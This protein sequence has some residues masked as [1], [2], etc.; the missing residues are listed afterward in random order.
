MNGQVEKLNIIEKLQKVLILRNLKNND[1]TAYQN[2]SSLRLKMDKEILELA[3]KIA[4]PENYH[5]FPEHYQKSKLEQTTNKG[6]LLKYLSPNIQEQICLETPNLLISSSPDIQIKLGPSHPELITSFDKDTQLKI[7]FQNGDLLSKCYESVQEEAIKQKPELIYYCSLNIKRDRLIENLD[8]TLWESY[9]KTPNLSMKNDELRIL[10]SQLPS[11]TKYKYE[12][13]FYESRAEEELKEN[14]LFERS[15]TINYEFAKYCN[16]ETQN[17]IYDIVQSISSEQAA[18]LDEKRNSPTG[19]YTRYQDFSESFILTKLSETYG[20]DKINEYKNFINKLYQKYPWE[21]QHILGIFLNEKS[22]IVEKV[23]PK[24]VINFLEDYLNEDK[25]KERKNNHEAK[26]YYYN[27]FFDLI[28]EAYGKE[29]L[30]ILKE[31]PGLNFEDI[32]NLEVF[33]PEI[34]NNFS[35]GFIHDLLNYDFGQ[36]EFDITKIA[37]NP[38]DLQAFKLYYSRISKILGENATTMKICISR[39]REY[40]NILKEASKQNL[41]EEQLQKLDALCTWPKNIANI[42]KIEELDNLE[43]KLKKTII[44]ATNEKNEIFD[45]KTIDFFN[46]NLESENI[47]FSYLNPPKDVLDMLSSKEIETLNYLKKTDLLTKYS[48][49]KGNNTTLNQ[50]IDNNMSL[51]KIFLD[52]YTLLTKIKNYE[53]KKFQEETITGRKEIEENIQENK[54]DAK[55]VIVDGIEIIDLGTMPVNF[56]IHNPSMNNSGVLENM[57]NLMNENLIFEGKSGIS[58]IS[59]NAEWE[60]GTYR[61]MG[62][63]GIRYI[64]WNFD[65]NEIMAFKGNCIEENSYTNGDSNVSHVGKLIKSTGDTN[66]SLREYK[67]QNAGTE[68]AFYRR[69]RDHKKIEESPRYGGKIIPDAIF[70]SFITPE[71]LQ[72]PTK[73]F[74]RNIPIICR[75][76]LQT[77]KNI[78]E[79]TAMIKNQKEIQMFNQSFQKVSNAEEQGH[80]R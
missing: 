70:A 56:A 10:L 37:K 71:I 45:L 41:T 57:E 54:Y 69:Y 68:I 8:S 22:S 23:E 4:S 28:K 16:L 62:V 30:E 74:G 7:A 35:K 79:I 46:T 31:R 32:D 58:T 61:S 9:L 52:K 36:E 14:L 15:K 48:F 44:V 24:K 2:I 13:I 42:T 43:E 20:N 3:W 18:F 78:R 26:A 75:G 5:E 77:E 60:N 34:L 51:S 29:A 72:L 27:E 50:A 39:Y 33:S 63:G 76:T 1:F 19:T 73:I 11:E 12:A 59:A 64:Y 55:R 66:S 17:K 53:M 21:K 49:P 6:A 38:E 67:N 25:V 65:S 40:K 80:S 47:L